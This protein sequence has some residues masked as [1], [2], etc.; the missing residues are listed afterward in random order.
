MDSIWQ[1]AEYRE[2]IG[3]FRASTSNYEPVA[4]AIQIDGSAVDE[5]LVFQGG[6]DSTVLSFG[7]LAFN[8]VFDTVYNTRTHFKYVT[9]IGATTYTLDDSAIKQLNYTEKAVSG[10]Q[11]SFGDFVGRLADFTL[12]DT[13]GTYD[14]VSFEGASGHLYFGVEKADTSIFW[15]DYGTFIVDDCKRTAATI[16]FALKDKRYLFDSTMSAIASNKTLFQMAQEVCTQAGVALGTVSGDLP[17]ASLTITNTTELQSKTLS[18][19][20]SAIAQATGTFAV[21]GKDDKLYF[22]WYAEVSPIVS[23]P[24]NHINANMTVADYEVA[25]TGV[26]WTDVD[27]TAYT[28]GTSDYLVKVSGNPFEFANYNTLLT[29]IAARVIGTSYV[30]ISLQYIGNPAIEVGDIIVVTDKRGN[31]YSLPVTSIS[32][33]NL[34]SQGLRSVGESHVSNASNTTSATTTIETAKQEAIAFAKFSE[35]VANRVTSGRLQSTDG[36]TY[37]DLDGTGVLHTDGDVEAN[38]FTGSNLWCG[39]RAWFEGIDFYVQLRNLYTDYYDPI[40]FNATHNRASYDTNGTTVWSTDATYLF[41]NDALAIY[42]GNLYQFGHADELLYK[43]SVPNDIYPIGTV[44]YTTKT[45]AQFN[46]AT[47]WG[48]SWTYT[49]GTPNKWERTA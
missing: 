5:T 40:L 48:G 10:S 1:T 20:V 33:R 43:L 37:F 31:A 14:A 19:L 16:W 4:N 46:P 8:H 25:V 27:G 23:I 9:T 45:S 47:A 26:S 15:I 21:I 18:Q 12:F 29:A 44:Y 7:G 32:I 28:S 2:L 24:S 34:M 41:I 35:I 38:G 11:F 6:Y 17:N 49:S 13:D 30:P 36:A 22:K 3:R 39:T 42:N